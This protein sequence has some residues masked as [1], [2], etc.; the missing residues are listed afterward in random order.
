MIGTFKVSV[1]LV[2]GLELVTAALLEAKRHRGVLG[3]L[4]LEVGARRSQVLVKLHLGPVLR[5]VLALDEGRGLPGL[6]AGRVPLGR[7]SYVLQVRD[8]LHV[9]E[10]LPLRVPLLRAAGLPHLL[11]EALFETQCVELAP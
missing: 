5:V 7:G 9:V 2:S 1:I 11:C 4:P 6:D 3:D 10:S 8:G